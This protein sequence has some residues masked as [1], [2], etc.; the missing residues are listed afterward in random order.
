M[1]HYALGQIVRALA[2]F[3]PFR[4]RA[5][6]SATYQLILIL[7]LRLLVRGVMVLLGFIRRDMPTAIVA[8]WG[9]FIARIAQE[10]TS[11]EILLEPRLIFRRQIARVAR[12]CKIVPAAVACSS[13]PV[14]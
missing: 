13:I 8:S 11:L 5:K 12:Q 3:S 7:M 6:A 4:P 1:T 2:G 10:R 9:L 14:R